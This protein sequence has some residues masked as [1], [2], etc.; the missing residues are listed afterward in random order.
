[1]ITLEKDCLGGKF[2]F[3]RQNAAHLNLKTMLLLAMLLFMGPLPE[4][5]ISEVNLSFGNFLAKYSSLG[6]NVLNRALGSLS[7]GAA[8]T[9]SPG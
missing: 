8:E 2:V 5:H 3:S 9:Q 4:K 7:P 1:M 6:C